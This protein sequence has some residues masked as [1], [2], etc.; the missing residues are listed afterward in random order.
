MLGS[1]IYLMYCLLK[2]YIMT[3]L[4]LPVVYNNEGVL[5]YLNSIRKFPV[6][7]A[8]SE[9]IL[10]KRYQETGDVEAAKNLVTSHLRLA[11]KVAFSFR[12]YGLPVSDLI[13]EANLG[14]MTAVKKFNPD[15]GFRLSTYA[16]WWIK[17]ELHDFILRSWSL[18]RIGT[19]A[20]QKKLFYNLNR[21][22]AKLGLYDKAS[23]DD[24]DVKKVA[25]ALDVDEQEVK[26]MEIRL[27]GDVSLNVPVND[28]DNM[29][30]REDFL[31]DSSPSQEVILA[32]NQEYAMRRTKLYN[33]LS[34]LKDRER[35]ILIA[36]RLQDEPSTLEELSE[37]YG[38]SRERVRQIEQRA[39]EKLTAAVLG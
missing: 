12:N 36:R 15:K 9:Y 23:L 34:G 30:E 31:V 13:S 18:V 22:K 16:I 26:D 14:L 3:E 29:A 4:A 1:L 25:Q 32:E 28:D 6:L 11:A 39:Y 10:A 7:D 38:I 5:S 19:V 8:E 37:K 35:E 17:A 27:S 24:N 20:A 33:A 21:I 2:G